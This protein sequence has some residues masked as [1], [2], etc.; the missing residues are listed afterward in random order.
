MASKQQASRRY[1]KALSGVISALGLCLGA[2]LAVPGYAQTVPTPAQ[3]VQDNGLGPDWSVH[4]QATYIDQFHPSFPSA[5]EGPQSFTSGREL[6]HTFSY[7]LYLDRMLWDGAALIFDPEIFQGHG[8]SNTLGIG[9]FPNGEAA[10]SGFANLEYNTS[11][12]LVQ[13]TVGFGGG[14]ESIDDHQ[15]HFPGEVDVN[16]MTISVG[17]FAANDLFDD[18]DYSHDPR[19]QFMNDAMW[20]SGAWD[21]PAD[22]VGFTAGAV[23]EWNAKDS[24]WHYGIFME[25][26]TVNGARLD[27]HVAKANGEI[28]QYDRRYR[29]DG[30]PGT[31]RAFVYWNRGKMGSYAD[32]AGQPYPEST[33][34]TRAYRSKA[35]FGSSWN[36]ELTAD[37]GAF[38]RLSWNDGRAETFAFT[39]IDRS[40]SGGLNL[41]GKSWGRPDD[42]VGLAVAVDGLS[43]EHSHYLAEGGLG[44]L[45]GDGALSYEPEQILEAYYGFQPRPW[46]QISPDFQYIRNPGY[47]SVRGPVPIYALRTHIEF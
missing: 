3:A 47:N 6:E 25:P 22:S 28:L 24:A 31:L 34:P 10:K 37:L 30:H 26:T 15:A 11:R 36:Q 4:T 21:Y 43:P 38:V 9:G 45:L 13:Q 29:W 20:E 8:L 17:K 41:S 40:A 7:S 12:L 18:N 19:T 39:E 14:K 42:T 27:H 2:S 33:A 1:P 44:L 32:A 35:G 46:L 16:R 5:Y 23:V